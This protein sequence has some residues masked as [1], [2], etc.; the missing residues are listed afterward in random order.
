MSTEKALEEKALR[1]GINY[2]N[3]LDGIETPFSAKEYLADL[4]AALRAVRDTRFP[5]PEKPRVV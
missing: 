5:L 2:V 4:E 3:T 1:A